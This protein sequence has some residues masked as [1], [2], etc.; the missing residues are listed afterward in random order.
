[1]QRGCN[2][3]KGKKLNSNSFVDKSEQFLNCKKLKIDSLKAE[4]E[5]R[6]M[7]DCTFKPLTN[8]TNGRS[9]RNIKQFLQSQSNF[10]AKIDEKNN[11]LKQ[12]IEEENLRLM[13]FSP[14]INKK[15][16]TCNKENVHERLYRLKDKEKEI[17]VDLYDHIPKIT[18]KGERIVRQA[19]V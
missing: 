1:M 18:E 15:K 3:L 17:P 19:P 14:K 2:G 8:H 9:P 10:L 7:A 13:T 4:M 6:V 5:E 12:R 16:Y 11:H